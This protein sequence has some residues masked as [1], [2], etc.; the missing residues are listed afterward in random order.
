MTEEEREA[1]KSFK[2]EN[3]NNFSKFEELN[4][5]E[6]YKIRRDKIILDLLQRKNRQIDLMAQDL[7]IHGFDFVEFGKATGNFKKDKEK[8]KQLYE[9]QV[10]EA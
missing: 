9:K 5:Y 8:L 4:D 7:L 1:I 6:R 2:E 10:K 3:D